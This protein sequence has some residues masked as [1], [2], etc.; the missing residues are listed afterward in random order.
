MVTSTIQ[1]SRRG[2]LVPGAAFVALAA[3]ASGA[4]HGPLDDMP[5]VAPSGAA[6]IQPPSSPSA[7]SEP[8]R[9]SPASAFLPPGMRAPGCASTM[10]I[11]AGGSS[12]LLA[13]TWSAGV[14]AAPQALSGSAAS[15]PTLV[16]DGTAWLGVVQATGNTLLST[17]TTPAAS[18]WSAPSAI[19]GATSQGTPALVSLGASSHLVYRGTDSKFYHAVLSGG[20]WDAANDPVGGAS[21]QS[22]GPSAPTAAAYGSAF[23]IV[24]SGNDTNVYTQEWSAVWS[25]AAPVSGSMYAKASASPRIARLDT[26]ESLVVFPHSDDLLLYALRVGAGWLSAMALHNVAGSEI[27][28]S[29]STVALAALPGG[30]ALLVFVG[31]DGRPRWSLYPKAAPLPDPLFPTSPWTAPVLVPL[32]PGTTLASPPEAAT[33]V[34]GHDAVLVFATGA[35]D[36]ELM[37]FDAAAGAWSMPSVVWGGATSATSP[38]A[39]YATNATAPCLSPARRAPPRYA[40]EMLARLR[41]AFALVA[42]ITCGCAPSVP[43]AGMAERT[44]R[45]YSEDPSLLELARLDPITDERALLV[46]FPR[47]PCSGSARMVFTDARGTFVGAVAPGDAAILAVPRNERQLVAIS[48]VE[49]TAPVGLT[50]ITDAVA[51]PPAPN[52]LLLRTRCTWRTSGQ[53]ADSAAATKPELEAAIAD[54]SLRWLEPRRAEGQAWLDEHRPR[55]DELFGRD[56]RPI[57]P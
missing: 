47:G 3:C 51:V 36:V 16:W 1:R 50:T 21:S 5:P 7:P 29:P 42:A 30:G 49:I 35:G 15:K 53:Y 19:A 43:V 38:A 10:A 40:R 23:V 39:T 20:A 26:G 32:P 2:V 9:D 8:S 46:V 37:S 33:G 52:G 45:A 41:A 27:A 54:A 14:W 28:A 11:L 44:Q 17:G 48:S 55:V 31:A 34:C 12:G 57:R 18:T 22:F 24:Q 6:T 25:A 13:S 4:A 56:R